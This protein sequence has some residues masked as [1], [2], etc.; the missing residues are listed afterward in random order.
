MP[1]PRLAPPDVNGL[2][3]RRRLHDLLASSSR[4]ITWVTGP[5]GAGKTSLI[6]EHVQ[7]LGR[8]LIWYHATDSDHDPA[9]FAARFLQAAA[10]F[11]NRPSKASSIPSSMPDDELPDPLRPLFQKLLSQLPRDALIVLDGVQVDRATENA[12]FPVLSRFAFLPGDVRTFVTSRSAPPK[13]FTRLAVDRAM[14]LL[15]WEDLRFT[16]QESRDLLSRVPVSDEALDALIRKADGWVAGLILLADGLRRETGMSNNHSER[17]SGNLSDALS[18]APSWELLEDVFNY[19]DVELFR[20]LP[21]DL[22]NFLLRIAFLSR[23][24]PAMAAAVSG[25]ENAEDLLERLRADN[26][27]VIRSP[28]AG[29]EYRMHPLWALFLRSAARKRHSVD[30]LKLLRVRS[31]EQLDGIGKREE[32][33]RLLAEAGDFPRLKELILRHADRLAADGRLSV[34]EQWIALLPQPV[35][36]EDPWIRY[37]LGNCLY[38]KDQAQG[39][40]LFRCSFDAFRRNQDVTGMLRAWCGAVDTFLYDWSEFHGLDAWIEDLEEVV[41]DGLALPATV[42]GIRTASSMIGAL[43]YRRPE[44]SDQITAWLDRAFFH[45]STLGARQVHV[46]AGFH[47]AYHAMWEGDLCR[48]RVISES[49][50]RILHQSDAPLAH[51]LKA[52]SLAAFVQSVC[53]GRGDSALDLVR[54][55]LEQGRTYGEKFWRDRLLAQGVLGALTQ[56]DGAEAKRYLSRLERNVPRGRRFARGYYHFAAAAV[57]LYHE[58]FAPAEHHARRALA[59]AEESGAKCAWPFF[60]L[61][62]ALACFEVGED[63]ECERIMAELEAFIAKS[64]SS[65][66]QFMWLLCSAYFNL[67]RERREPGLSFLAKAFTLGRREGYVNVFWLWR[68]KMMSVLCSAALKH[69]V[70]KE[71]ASFLIRRHNLLPEPGPL[72]IVHWPWFLR[73]H[74]LGRFEL[75]RD[76]RPVLLEG[77]VQYR[78]LALLK[79]LAVLGDQGMGEEELCGLLWPESD[80]EQARGALATTLSRLRKML[81]SKES[82]VNSN[83][84]FMLNPALC[85]VDTRA[86]SR[87]CL[88]SRKAEEIS[89]A[90]SASISSD[91]DPSEAA[92]LALEI[93]KGHLLPEDMAY[94]WTIPARERLRRMFH[95]LVVEHGDAL[96][97]RGAWKEA[98]TFYLR[99][100]DADDLNEDVYL[101]LMRCASGAGCPDEARLFWRLCQE[102]L[103]AEFNVSPS[104]EL[105]TLARSL[106]LC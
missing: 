63:A 72:E 51:Q 7:D 13:D 36:E 68:P 55:G 54:E 87:L 45:V 41:A 48:L 46:H 57:C 56:G 30:D 73:I 11:L 1:H 91:P 14:S 47:A 97:N 60:A 80:L 98:R 6:A 81:D 50:Q 88:E 40:A 70:A 93:Y 43:V 38:L 100:L 22:R 9:T 23:M 95:A 10:P 71:Y 15:T 101:R 5:P 19:L 53:N 3:P 61:A 42:L 75:I 66:H 85:W 92:N 65:M 20:K 94:S 39:R 27:L 64:R 34:L 2:I 17:R 31:A 21:A 90:A 77:K 74:T 24:T 58:E 26:C 49:I 79:M 12:L 96:E 16:D 84:K 37:W 25:T 28:T 4:S 99:V 52:K 35:V 33:A 18:R 76:G 82:I 59:I 78:P 89:D 32:A 44:Q 67:V 106:G 69:S 104:F 83:G 102:R 8:P 103:R 29:P 86:F 62:L 105:S